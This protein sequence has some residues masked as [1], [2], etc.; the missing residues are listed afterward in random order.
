M[1]REKHLQFHYDFH[2]KYFYTICRSEDGLYVLLGNLYGVANCESDAQ[3]NGM[4]MEVTDPHRRTV[5][6][7]KRSASSSN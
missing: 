2:Q 5:I 3:F 6:P 7:K 4:I 1:V